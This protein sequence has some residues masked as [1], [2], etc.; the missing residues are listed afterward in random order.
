MKSAGK[1]KMETTEKQ[2]IKTNYKTQPE[3][4]RQIRSSKEPTKVRKLLKKRGKASI[5]NLGGAQ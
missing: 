2:E 1:K 4:L 3:N 5:I